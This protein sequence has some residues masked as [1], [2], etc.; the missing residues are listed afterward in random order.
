MTTTKD[1]PRFAAT[2]ES[3]R[4]A[5]WAIEHDDALIHDVAANVGQIV[6][7]VK[8]TRWFRDAVA[9]AI[10]ALNRADQ[11]RLLKALRGTR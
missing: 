7:N 5:A 3:Q 4:L 2:A 10:E 11:A 6:G 1:A 9:E 8:H